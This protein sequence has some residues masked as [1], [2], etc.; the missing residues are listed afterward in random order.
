MTHLWTSASGQVVSTA[1]RS[2][3][4]PLLQ[5]LD[6]GREHPDHGVGELYASRN[7]RSFRG[8]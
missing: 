2:P 1:V 6:P 8:S 4:A 5:Q 3:T 7:G